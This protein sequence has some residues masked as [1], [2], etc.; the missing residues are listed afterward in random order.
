MKVVNKKYF[1]IEKGGG[2]VPTNYFVTPNS[3]GGCFDWC[4][5][6]NTI[7]ELIVIWTNSRAAPLVRSVPDILH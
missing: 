4:L 3:S 2:W 5:S 7:L 1:G 6:K